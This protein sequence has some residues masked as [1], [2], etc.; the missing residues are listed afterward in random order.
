MRSDY[1]GRVSSKGL[2][3]VS[4]FPHLFAELVRPG[5]RETAVTF[6]CLGRGR[7]EGQTARQATSRFA[8][9]G[10]NWGRSRAEAS[11]RFSITSTSSDGGTGQRETP[12]SPIPATMMSMQ[13]RM[14]A[15]VEDASPHGEDRWQ[16]S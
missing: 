3:N 5:F 10:L 13:R 7:R 6:S 15:L 11:A 8:S 2:E 9:G 4:R 16:A 14:A 1:F 12:S